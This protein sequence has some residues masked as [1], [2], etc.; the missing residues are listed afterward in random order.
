MVI[1]RPGRNGVIASPGINHIG[2]IIANNGVIAITANNVFKTINA[3]CARGIGCC[4]ACGKV[5]LCA[6]GIAH[7]QGIA[8]FTPRKHIIPGTG[9]DHVIARTAVNHI[10]AGSAIKLIIA[11]APQ[12]GIGTLTAQQHIVTIA[13]IKHI[14]AGPARK[15]I[16]ARTARKGV[17][18]RI[19]GKRI[20]A[21]ATINGVVPGTAANGVIA[22]TAGNNVVAIIGPQDVI[23]RAA[24]NGNIAIAEFLAGQINNIIA[25]PGLDIFDIH[26]RGLVRATIGMV[27]V[28]NNGIVA[29]AGNQRV[30]AV[31]P[32]KTVGRQVFTGNI[33]NFARPRLGWAAHIIGAVA[34]IGRRIAFKFQDVITR[35]G[36]N[37]VCA[38]AAG[39]G[40]GTVTAKQAVITCATTQDVIAIRPGKGVIP[41]TAG[42]T[43]DVNQGIVA[44]ARLGCAI[45]K[46]GHNRCGAVTIIG[47]I[48]AIATHQ[49]II[50]ATGLQG[51]VSGPAQN[52]VVARTAGQHIIPGTARNDVILIIASD[53]VV[54]I[55]TIDIF[56]PGQGIIARRTASGSRCQI[57]RHTT[58]GI[59]IR[60][61]IRAKAA[62]QGII[63]ASAQHRVISGT[64]IEDIGILIANQDVIASTAG[65]IFNI[66]KDIIAL[67]S[68][69]RTCAQIHRNRVF[70]GT[71]IGSIIAI[72][73][74][75]G[76]VPGATNQ[77]IIAGTGINDIIAIFAIN[78]V[79]AIQRIDFITKLAA[80]Q[81]IVK[82]RALDGDIAI[83]IA[84]PE[85]VD[86]N[87]F[88]GQGF[89][90]GQGNNNIAR[91]I[92]KHTIRQVFIGFNAIGRKV[93]FVMFGVKIDNIVAAPPRRNHNHVITFTG[94]DHIIRC[95]ADQGIIARPAIQRGHTIAANQGIGIIGANYMFDIA[96]DVVATSPAGILVFQV[97][98]NR[99]IHFGI[100]GCINAIATINNVVPGI[101]VDPVLP[102]IALQDIVARATT[103]DIIASPGI[104][105]V[106]ARAAHDGVVAI[107]GMNVI[108]P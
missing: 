24:I 9:L 54:K 38:Q 89:I 101:A 26:D 25:V 35:P 72:A 42:Q 70:G 79:I 58:I 3:V 19:T 17:I 82:F 104:D 13:A 80:I 107:T 21:V 4:R 53:G 39:Q 10:I 100:I 90:G 64:P 91:R 63:A 51:V 94:N 37:Q 108:R 44:L 76:I 29:R 92:G 73:A 59:L 36:I 23:A 87:A 20:I 47:H 85:V 45:G 41:V 78:D 27:T 99:A 52:G 14:R 60:H 66:I 106:V 49:R 12:Q 86:I 68:A 30:S 6:V 15:G 43:F 18:A 57:N 8:A 105:R 69:C 1:T 75:Q 97:N 84:R 16:V 103:Q 81:N 31:P 98:N 102:V 83:K 61:L 40:I 74:A 46:V 71:I 56:K 7:I 77:G 22:G 33:G 55:R 2:S 34:V 50:A 28:Q 62:N 67:G 11:I 88:Q 65:D 48:T 95:P 5:N 32:D 93:D 96:N